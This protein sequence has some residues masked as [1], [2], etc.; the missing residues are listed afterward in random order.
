MLRGWAWGG[1]RK[2]LAPGGKS[3]LEGLKGQGLE[4]P[5]APGKAGR[6]I[7]NSRGE[8]SVTSR[9]ALTRNWAWRLS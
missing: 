6:T 8:N 1:G 9:V 5:E 4:V 3:H 2:C 7:G